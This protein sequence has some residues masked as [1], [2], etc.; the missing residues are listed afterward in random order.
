MAQSGDIISLGEQSDRSVA[1]YSGAEIMRA[2]GDEGSKQDGEKSE[3]GGAS[4][5]NT[6]SGSEPKLSRVELDALSIEARK[7]IEAQSKDL[8]SI[9]G[10]GGLRI[11]VAEEGEGW[12]TDMANGEVTVDPTFFVAEGYRP[13]WCVY[14]TAHE[15]LAHLKI[16]VADPATAKREMSHCRQ[17]EAHN[18]FNNILTDIAGNRDIARN[19][20]NMKEVAPRIYGEKLFP[21]D[22]YSSRPR[23]IQFLYKIIRD[24]MIPGT[25]ATV[26]PEVAEAISRLRDFRGGGED[27]IEMATDPKR[28]YRERQELQ[29]GPIWEEFM[30]LLR[31]DIEEAKKQQLIKD[32]T[33]SDDPSGKPSKSQSTMPSDRA[34]GR[35]AGELFPE[36]YKDAA[37][38]HPEPISDDKMRDIINHAAKLPQNQTPEQRAA[39]AVEAQ[40]GHNVLELNA[41]REVL[42]KHWPQVE[43]LVDGYF[44]KIIEKRLST[45]TRQI[46][47]QRDGDTIDGNALAQGYADMRGGSDPHVFMRTEQV[48][49]RNNA[50]GGYDVFLVIDGSGSMLGEKANMSGESSAIMLEA[51]NLFQSQ[52]EAS[53]SSHRV[54]LGL[55]VRS[56]VII[57]GDEASVKKPLSS[58]LTEKSRLDAY[59]GAIAAT[60][61]STND[62]LAYQEIISLYDRELQHEDNAANRKRLVIVICDGASDNQSQS[63][64][65]MA[66]LEERG[67]MV[68][69]I[70][71]DVPTSLPND[72]KISNPEELPD[73]LIDLLQREI[74]K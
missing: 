20:P 10:L 56:E 17:S 1:T 12:S 61:G 44:S 39:S 4:E 51:L 15:L 13:E 37:A 19:L 23:H 50:P 24:S 31:Q 33:G 73:A 36:D 11:G 46:G 34:T 64:A 60:S 32:G 67:F 26:V 42:S 6:E 14:A 69:R 59:T 41:F 66:S 35:A 53:E 8:A 38:R 29:H 70:L 45:V 49:R 3:T 9:V 54:S 52:I 58:E 16:A 48:E 5:P 57:Y 55:D 68:H 18:L 7:F 21:E 65:D 30:S 71:I 27:V 62:Y 2:I 22:D 40:T 74:D 28:T 47:S 43:E 63:D 72:R 25:D